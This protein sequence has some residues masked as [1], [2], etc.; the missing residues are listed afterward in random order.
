MHEARTLG[1]NPFST[2]SHESR[3]WIEVETQL[4]AVSRNLIRAHQLKFSLNP[5]PAFVKRP[6]K[7]GLIPN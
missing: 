1:S 6:S 4:G 7:N 2:A 3:L 5:K